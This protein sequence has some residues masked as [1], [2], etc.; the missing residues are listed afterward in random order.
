VYVAY[1]RS[2][3]GN[4]EAYIRNVVVANSPYIRLTNRN[5]YDVSPYWSP[6]GTK[7][8]VRG[9]VSGAD[10]IF[11][12]SNLTGT[13]SV[14]QVTNL[15]NNYFHSWSPDSTKIVFMST[16]DANAEI[17]TMD[18]N[19]GNQTRLTNTVSGESY[20]VWSA[21]A[22]QIAYILSGDIHIMN[23]DGSNVRRM[24][25]PGRTESEIVWW[26]TKQAQ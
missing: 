16:R 23:A 7:I 3:A 2:V 24:T 18:A 9:T 6:D 20:P 26:Q 10:Q 1:V 5:G 22:R 19:G 4:Q 11:I 12:I 8:A 21:D 13:P 17:Y 14:Q 25:T 15:G